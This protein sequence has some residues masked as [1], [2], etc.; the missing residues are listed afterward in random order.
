MSIKSLIAFASRILKERAVE[1]H[2]GS[3]DPG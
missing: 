3:S 2:R 1:R